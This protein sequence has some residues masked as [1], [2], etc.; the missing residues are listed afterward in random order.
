MDTQA[1]RRV[2]EHLEKREGFDMADGCNCI[3]HDVRAAVMAAAAPASDNI[4]YVACGKALDLNHDEAWELF[5]MGSVS[6]KDRDLGNVTK[7]EALT[8]LRTMAENGDVWHIWPEVLGATDH[9][10]DK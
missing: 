2:I 10:E 8:A 4:D 7:T 3:M 1:F 6:H 9:A 5:Y